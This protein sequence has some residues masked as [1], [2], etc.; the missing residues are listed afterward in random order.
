MIVWGDG[1]SFAHDANGMTMGDITASAQ[2]VDK[3]DE[4]IIFRSSGPW[5]KRWIDWRHP[6]K[7]FHV[8]GKSSDWGPHAGLVPFDGTYSKVGADPVKAAKG[9]AANRDGLHSNFAGTTPL[10]LSR[11]QID[12]QRT[13]PE[14]GKNAIDEVRPLAQSRDLLLV[15]TRSGAGSTR[16]CFRACHDESTGRY[17]IKVWPVE[18]PVQNPFLVAE[19]PA[20]DFAPFLVMTSREVGAHNRP[21]TGDYDL[22]AVCPTWGQ[23]GSKTSRVI[24]KAGIHL[25]NDQVHNDLSFD[26]GVGMDNVLDTR[27]HTM[28]RATAN[29]ALPLAPRG[30]GPSFDPRTGKQ[31]TRRPNLSDFHDRQAYYRQGSGFSSDSLNL[32]FDNSKDREHQDMGNLT[33]RILRCINEFNSAM[34]ATGD[35]SALRR[36][37]HNAESH[38]N[39][40][41]GGI[42][43]IDM[44]T[45][46]DGDKYGDGF[47][48]T[49]F[50][51]KRLVG[52]YFKHAVC[53]I[54][55]LAEFRTY[56]AELKAAGFYVP[57]N[58]IWNL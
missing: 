13:D 40:K 45:K 24:R 39:R 50:H 35:Q 38:R 49:A 56:A 31:L 20:T 52:G 36:V 32:I 6:T 2:V 58:W 37:H 5:C 43:E 48:L 30:Q 1:A 3:L 4:V 12:T 42:T 7:N 8:K 25:D 16:I 34:G 10:T 22:M 54:E 47:P 46:K 27:F 17:E 53:T 28:G 21:L 41:W 44:N 51:P 14:G 18:R 26:V 15:A 29:A 55:T 9:T 19:K 57:K 33:P 23:Y 11:L